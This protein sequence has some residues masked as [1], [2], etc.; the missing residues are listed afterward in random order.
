MRKKPRE[1]YILIEVC[2]NDIDCRICLIDESNSYVVKTSCKH[3]F[4]K[5]C[6]DEWLKEKENC[7]LCR[8][9]IRNKV[10]EKSEITEIMTLTFIE[11]SIDNFAL[12]KYTKECV[13]KNPSEEHTKMEN[14][15]TM[16]NEEV[17][18]GEKSITQ[19]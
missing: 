11:K 1:T 10:S 13:K 16:N 18:S 8:T 17:I 7:S 5:E 19:R 12:Q 3:I 4:H 15:S 14:E 6:I 2:E 9:I